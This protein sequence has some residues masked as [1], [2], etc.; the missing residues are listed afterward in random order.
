MDKIWNKGIVTL[1]Y[2]NNEAKTTNYVTG[3]ITKSTFERRDHIDINTG[4]ITTDDRLAEFSLMSKKMGL[5]YLTDKMIKYFK[6]RK[7]FV[8]QG[9]GGELISMPRYYK[10]KIFTPTELSEMYQEYINLQ[11]EN[12]E[13]EINDIGSEYFRRQNEQIK[14]LLRQ[15]EKENKLKRLKL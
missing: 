11:D 6:D 3:Y 13:Q 5:S 14:A 8:I 7:I 9:P 10:Q 12:I 15:T 4:L 1:E 2:P